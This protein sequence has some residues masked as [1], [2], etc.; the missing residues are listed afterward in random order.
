MFYG[1]FWRK[2]SVTTQTFWL[3]QMI[4]RSARKQ[5]GIYSN[6]LYYVI[7]FSQFIFFYVKDTRSF[8]WSLSPLRVN[9]DSIQ[10]ETSALVKRLKETSKK[11]S[12][13]IDDVKQQ[14][15]KIIAVSRT[16]LIRLNMTSNKSFPRGFLF[17]TPGVQHLYSSLHIWSIFHVFTLGEPGGVPNSRGTILRDW[18]AEAWAGPVLV[19]GQQPALSGGPVRN[20]QD[21]PWPLYQGHKGWSI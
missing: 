5:L 8:L 15:N 7:H 13:S 4:L 11:V 19:W 12:D 20:H 2:Q 1:L 16:L 3:C 14:Y 18:Q 17:L 21:F 6:K 9:M 10:A